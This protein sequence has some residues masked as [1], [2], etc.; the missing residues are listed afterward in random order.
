MNKRIMLFEFMT[1]PFDHLSCKA[2][3][4]SHGYRHPALHQWDKKWLKNE[5][6]LL[7]PLMIMALPTARWLFRKLGEK[8]L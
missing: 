7:G 8:V 1:E 5:I 4:K 2:C 3:K 6:I